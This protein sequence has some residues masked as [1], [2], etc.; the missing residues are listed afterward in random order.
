[1]TLDYVPS[2]ELVMHSNQAVVRQGD[3]ARQHGDVRR[4][5]RPV[6]AA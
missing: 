4:V 5:H 2:F 1:M 6:R 3:F